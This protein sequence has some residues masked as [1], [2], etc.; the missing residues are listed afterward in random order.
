M[1]IGLLRKGLKEG[2]LSPSVCRRFLSFHYSLQWIKYS[3]G[4]GHRL[5][6]LEGI[7]WSE[8]EPKIAKTERGFYDYHRWKHWETVEEEHQ[9]ALDESLME[10]FSALSS[11]FSEEQELSEPFQRIC[12]LNFNITRLSLNRN[13]PEVR[14]DSEDQSKAGSEEGVYQG[15][16][17]LLDQASV[18]NELLAEFSSLK[19]QIF[20]LENLEVLVGLAVEEVAWFFHCLWDVSYDPEGVDPARFDAETK[21]VSDTLTKVGEVDDELINAHCDGITEILF[22]S[23]QGGHSG[24]QLTD[25]LTPYLRLIYRIL[26]IQ[27]IYLTETKMLFRRS[28]NPNNWPGKESLARESR[29]RINAILRDYYKILVD[30]LVVA[31]DRESQ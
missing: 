2:V 22:P 25:R 20:G 7:V 1:A 13:S 27:S 6:A 28:G 19:S 15:I 18:S 31:N 29:G 14:K 21:G 11:Q 3:L 23:P 16:M 5:P 17:Q 10:R 30:E 4:N 12:E 26:Q 8:L 9:G 24:N